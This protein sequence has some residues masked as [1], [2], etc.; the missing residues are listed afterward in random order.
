MEKKMVRV[1]LMSIHRMLFPPVKMKQDV[2]QI[3]NGVSL[4]HEKE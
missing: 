1:Y 4:S 2:V 3:Y